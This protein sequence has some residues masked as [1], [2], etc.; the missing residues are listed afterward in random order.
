MF[1][2]VAVLRMETI[3]ARLFS[4]NRG[5]TGERPMKFRHE[6]SIGVSIAGVE[7]DNLPNRVEEIDEYISSAGKI[8]RGS[9]T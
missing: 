3:L 9:T 1:Q 8:A 7:H 2:H 5:R 4:E 6:H